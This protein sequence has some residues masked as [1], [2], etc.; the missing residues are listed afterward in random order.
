MAR[1]LRVGLCCALSRSIGVLIASLM[2]VPTPG[3]A[4]PA[5]GVH[6]VLGSALLGMGMWTLLTPSV[7]FRDPSC[8]FLFLF[9]AA[10]PLLN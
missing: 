4:V 9:F 7:A 10:S 5:H 2:G 8:S 3:A 1:E 6:P